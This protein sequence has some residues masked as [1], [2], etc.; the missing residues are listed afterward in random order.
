VAIEFVDAGARTLKGKQDAQR[1]W[2]AAR[3]LAGVGGVLRIDGI[4]APLIG[5]DVELRLLKD[6]FHATVARQA[7]R[8]LLVTGAAGSGKSRLGWEFEKYTDGLADSVWWHRGRCLSYGDGVAFWAVAEMVRQ[9][10][11]IAEE[12]PAEVAL[13][14]LL[15][16]LERH[17]T[18]PGER[19]YVGVRLGRLLGLAHPADAGQELSREEL[20]AGWRTWLV[21]LA[22]TAPVLWLIEDLQNADVALLQFLDHLLDWA[23]T[24]PI[25]LLGFARP[26]LDEQHPEWSSGRN[27]TQLVL[28][29]LDD[30]SMRQLLGELVP[31]MPEAAVRAIADQAH[32][33]PLFAIET[34]RSLID[35]DIV[36]PRNGVYQLV[37]ELGELDVPDSLRA[38]LAARLDH[39]DPDLR[40]LVA[41]A[42]VLGDRFPAEALAAVSNR[43]ESSLRRSL[44]EL[45]Q[46]ELLTVTADPLSPQRGAYAFASELLRRVAYETLSR[47]DRKARHLAVAEHLRSTFGNDGEEVADVLA[48]HLLDA[49]DA[50]PEDAD[51]EEIRQRAVIELV[52]AGDR[53]EAT[54]APRR[55]ADDYRQA[56]EHEPDEARAAELWERAATAAGHAADFESS[57]GHAARGRDAYVANGDSRGAARCDTV[58]GLALFRAGRF[59]A[60]EELLT[61]ALEV[62]RAEP[63]VRRLFERRL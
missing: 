19:T 37:G 36:L 54:G 45:V 43:P 47:R 59:E 27:R 25:Y 29:P 34:I 17:I 15:E 4:E 40:A 16:G 57:V 52:R 7:P 2:R 18:E 41:D 38:L 63:G 8:L 49:L 62:L 13:P 20:F 61:T 6:L 39:L 10:L 35:R 32:G 26:E 21:R 53:A 28:D 42:A 5:R 31:G 48:R 60:A 30:A 1:L 9:R 14:K 55:A 22:D 11:G 24:A 56:A 46:R 44:Q 51:A 58:A 3:V 12:D 23:R 50:V 33:V